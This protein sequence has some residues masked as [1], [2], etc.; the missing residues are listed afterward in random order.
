MPVSVDHAHHSRLDGTLRVVCLGFQVH[1]GRLVGFRDMVD[2]PA[3]E[4]ARAKADD[5]MDDFRPDPEPEPVVT[6]GVGH[7]G[8]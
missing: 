4:G 2:D 5:A 6:A 7:P 8:P 3:F 1:E